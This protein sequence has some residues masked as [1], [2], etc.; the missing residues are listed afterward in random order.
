MPLLHLSIL[1]TL[2]FAEVRP[3]SD[4]VGDQLSG[5]D[6]Y[7]GLEWLMYGAWD[8]GGKGLQLW[9]KKAGFDPVMFVNGG[10]FEITHS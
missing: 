10:K 6:R 5:I 7:G 8:S 3:W 4:P 9:K 2:R 1:S